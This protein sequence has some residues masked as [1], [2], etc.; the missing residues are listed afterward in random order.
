MANIKIY[1]QCLRCM[2]AGKLTEKVEGIPTLLDPCPVCG[3][4]GEVQSGTLDVT[5]IKKIQDSIDDI[6]AMLDSPTLGL[7]KMSSNL[8]DIMVKLDV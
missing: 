4:S 8:D 3:G 2:G 1:G 6:K 7:Q 5:K